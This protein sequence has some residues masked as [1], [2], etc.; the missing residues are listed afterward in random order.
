MAAAFPSPG[1]KHTGRKSKLTPE[2][3][4]QFIETLRLTGN[5]RTAAMRVGVSEKT[6]CEWKVKGEQQPLG[7][8]TEFRKACMRTLADRVTLS[9]GIHFRVSHG[10]IYKAPRMVYLYDDK[11]SPTPTNEVAL[12]AEG[13]PVMVDCC[14]GVD[15]RAIEWELARI[16]PETYSQRAI[17]LVINQQTNVEVRPLLIDVL[18]EIGPLPENATRRAFEAWKR[19]DNPIDVTSPEDETRAAFEAW[20]RDEEETDDDS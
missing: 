7:I 18:K 12:D 5:Y 11:N 1:S 16:E 15:L 19:G 13:K 4:K 6:I 10:Q 9:A 20:K 8:Y 14:D 2:L 17:D 3:Q